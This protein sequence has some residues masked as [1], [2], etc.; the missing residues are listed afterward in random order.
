MIEIVFSNQLVHSEERS[1]ND[2]NRK[3]KNKERD[4][5]GIGAV[6]R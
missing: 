1:I 5:W 2:S 6:K 3:A 4:P